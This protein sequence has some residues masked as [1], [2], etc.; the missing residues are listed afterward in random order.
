MER[1][2]EAPAG[3]PARAGDPSKAMRDA[4]RE[5][6]GHAIDQI[7]KSASI[8]VL[9]DALAASTDFGAVVRALRDPAAF[10]A[11]VPLDPLTDALARGVAERENLAAKAQGLLSAEEA[12]RI[13]GGISRQA[14]DKRRRAGQLLGV[15]LAN[16]WR[17]PA[18]QFGSAGEV[19]QGLAD[20]L[21]VLA[22]L[23]PWATLDF[24]LAEDDALGGLSP[25][26]ALRQ[27]G[28]RTEEVLRIAQ[29]QKA[30]VFG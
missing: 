30:D 24:L 20:V 13:L 18:L 27:G 28:H 12:G 16:D 5:R 8:E 23:S 22:D 21:Q 26:E 17:Y 29:V 11:T 14:V 1:A 3:P 9:A 2:A 15:R 4:F 10:P 19:A 25:L 7:A 6:A